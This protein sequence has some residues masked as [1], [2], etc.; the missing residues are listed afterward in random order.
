MKL[1]R[2]ILR[3][4]VFSLLAV[5]LL[6]SIT[7]LVALAQTETGQI[8]VK[9]TDPQG[10]VVSGAAVNV[11]ST[12]TGVERL[13]STNEEGIAIIT[14]LQPGVYD[15]TVSSSGFAPY[16]QQANVTV[17][18]RLNLEAALSVTTKGESVTVIAGDSGVE[19]NTQTQELSNVVSQKQITELPT[20]TRNPYALVAIS[21]NVAEGDPRS[22][23]MR[24]TGFA[25][26]G[27]RSASTNILL[28]GGENVDAFVAGVG[29]SVPLDGVQEFRIITS[30]F[31]AEYGRASGGIVNVATRAGSNTFHGSLYE[32]SRVS[33]LASNEFNDNANGIDKGV[34]TR[35]QFG[36]SAGGKVIKDK[37]FF[38]NSTEWTR[39]RSTGEIISIVPTPELINASNANTKAFFAPYQLATPINGTVY[40]V[41]DV[42]SLLGL[43]GANAFTNLSNNLP[44]FG[45]VRL[46]NATDLGGGIPGNDWQTVAR[47]DYN[48]SDKTQMYF[49]AAFEE[50]SQQK[51]AVNF[52]PYVGF[53]TGQSTRNQNY[54]FNV[55]RTLSSNLVNQSKVV[56]NRL[57]LQQPLAEQPVGP[58]L[59]INDT[60]TGRLAGFPIRFPGYSATTPGNAIPFGGPQN[61][62]QFYDDLN[63]T[64]GTHQFRFGGQYVHMRD[65]RTF[66]AFAN[67][68]EALSSSG[69][70]YSTA[71]A[72]LVSGQLRSFTVAV[73]P[74]GKLPC[75]TDPATGARVVTPDCT[76][77]TPLTSPNFS[78]SNRY[79]EWA[80]YFNDS[81]KIRPRLNLNLGL[82]YEYYGTQHN[83][84]QSLDSNFYFGEG[85]TIFER[86][87]NGQI[88]LAKDSPLGKLW[89]VDPNNVAPRVGFAWDVFGNGTTSLR[90]GYGIAYERNFG[91]VTFNVIQNPP[92]NATVA[93]TSGVDVP[94]G[95]LPITPVNLG[96]LAGTGSRSLAASSLRAVDPNIVNAYAHFWSAAIERQLNPTTV[97]SVEYSGSAGRHLYSISN[98]N[99]AGTGFAY[100]GIPRLASRLNN[101]GA[102]AINFRGSDGRSNYDALIVSVES[103][104]F[105]NWGLRFTGR[106]TYSQTKDNLSSAFSESGN[107]F[108][109]GYTDP[110]NPDLD[111]GYADFDNRHRFVGSWTWEIPTPKFSHRAA[112]TLLGGWE[113]TGIFQARSG[114]P[115]TVFDCTNGQQMCPRVSLDGGVNFSGSV[116]HKAVG[117]TDTPNR[118]KYI[119][120]SGLHP[121]AFV[122]QFGFGADFGPFPANMSKRNAFRGP[123][124][125]NLDGGVYKNIRITE[126]VKLQLRVEA[127]NV[128]NHANLFVSG[129][130]A[131]INNGATTDA[132]GNAVGGYVPANFFGRRNIQLAGKIIF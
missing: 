6:Y 49:R 26:N 48:W 120:L 44:A 83:A 96:P 70:S 30:N 52:S 11:K 71:L 89:K 3:K 12:S 80:V 126:S 85:S 104:R 77:Q 115:F 113:V 79:H 117:V 2:K 127:F 95:T 64:R 17:G 88:L 9:A 98:I 109:L 58:T 84:D 128:F 32:F 116:N 29:Q 43:S 110:F 56:F 54:L 16:K 100:G 129:G 118:Y 94:A 74:Q 57:T 35:N 119:D 63:W 68:V 106:Y 13:A 130:E 131:E 81:W 123:G 76:L 69:Q 14:A 51:G 59:F 23:T 39:V 47:F 124:F 62:L 91:N 40:T 102:S 93:S 34:F 21:G 22:M 112:E 75:H 72:N 7:P 50:G 92:N 1:K 114:L 31:S 53:D 8:T 46:P 82:R 65:N 125:W 5:F 121:G 99:R 28:D 4:T 33:A 36:Y 122:D 73:F 111:Y 90:G 86:I 55:T 45:Q 97:L 24:G 15:I 66:G 108:N 60:F 107:N 61:F 67:A 78:R 27:Q 42:K 87:K 41:G 19:V 25:I 10:A 132:N 37:L 103:S 18:A 101:N 38:F 105:R 20:I